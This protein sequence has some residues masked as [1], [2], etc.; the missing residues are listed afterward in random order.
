MKTLLLIFV[1]MSE[2]V[3][4]QKTFTNQNN[5][6]SPNAVSTY[7]TSNT[8]Y[9]TLKP[10]SFSAACYTTNSTPN[11]LYFTDYY[12]PRDSGFVTGNNVYGDLEKAQLYYNSNALSI[13]GC[14]AM[15]R[16]TSSGNN[17]LVGSSIKIYDVNA[18]GKPG[19]LLGTSN[20]IAQHSLV[21][22]TYNTFTFTPA[23]N[24]ATDFFVSYVLPNNAG[25]TTGIYS[26]Y[27]NC[28][29]SQILAVEK[30]VDNSWGTIRG[31]WNFPTGVDID[32]ALLPLLPST[33]TT[34]DENT[35]NQLNYTITA[36]S[37]IVNTSNSNAHISVYDMLGN[38]VINTTLNTNH[39]NIAALNSGMY[40][41]VLQ[42]N[43]N[44]VLKGKFV[45]W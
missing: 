1:L 42:G 32:L 4:A 30:A 18:N 10:P 19:V 16:V 8:A 44:E 23:I 12:A 21:N 11:T 27:S 29:S 7:K 2:L 34:I 20:F 25:D 39:I 35:V 37:L 9:D 17:A 31:N 26:T 40:C 13:V 41:V 45:K 43:N 38:L 22:N 14:L 28:H 24:V 15:V 6:I 33:T 3:L 5:N 36:T